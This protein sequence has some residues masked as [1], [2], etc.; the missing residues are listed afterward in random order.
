MQTIRYLTRSKLK[1]GDRSVKLL[2]DQ[3]EYHRG[4]PVRLWVRFADEHLA[5]GKEDGVTVTLQHKEHQTRQIRLHRALAGGGVF[6]TVLSDLAAGSYHA[7]LA[8]P[9]VPGGAPW[10]QF[11]VVAPG[12]FDRVQMDAQ[13]MQRAAKQTKGQY[14]T[15]QTAD[16]L[17][18]ELPAGYRAPVD[19]AQQRPLWNSP[20]LLSAFLVLLVGEW[21]LRKMGGMV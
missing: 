21:V 4:E 14:Y 8:A 17:L 7:F 3:R 10:I 19:V 2:T 6:E 12:E 20:V 9:T 1:E 5:P 13:A 11:E 16:R 15:F 18:D